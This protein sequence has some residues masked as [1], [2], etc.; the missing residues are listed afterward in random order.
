M[1]ALSNELA[2][3]MIWIVD[4]RFARNIMGDCLGTCS[5]VDFPI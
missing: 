3:F 4:G 1:K 2:A 5:D